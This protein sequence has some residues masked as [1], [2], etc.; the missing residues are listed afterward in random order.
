MALGDHAFVRRAPVAP[1]P[2]PRG[3]VGPLA[4]LRNNL[5]SS[6]A[7][8]ATTILIALFLA[9]TVPPLIRWLFI[10]AAWTGD[11]R[12]VCLDGG[13]CWA[14]IGAKINLILYGQYPPD[15][16]W[17]IVLVAALFVAGLVPLAI[18]R[19]PG[20]RWNVVYLLVVFPVIAF[21]LLTGIGIGLDKVPTDRWGG[22]FVTLVAA[23][24]GIVI[25]LPLGILLALGRRSKLPVVRWLS[26][27][28]IEFWRGVPLVAVLFMASVM[29]PIFLPPGVTFDKLLRAMLCIAIF[30]SAYMAEVVRGGLQAVPKGQYEGSMA[31]GLSWF[32]QMRLVVM[33]QALTVVIPGIV[34]TF[35]ALFK[36]TSLIMVIGLFDLLGMLKSATN[37]S[38]W[39]SPSVPATAYVFAGIIYW[40]FCFGLS[41][42]SV[43]IERRLSRGK[44]HR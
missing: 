17:R 3:V 11:D 40:V 35:I 41:R 10:D 44:L 9:W 36:D 4:W 24:M 2:P 34:N 22:L 5:F 39:A 28:F 32:Q 15:E 33:P 30:Y 37:D 12:S 8:T 29:L 6:P 16:R 18:P 31:L 21:M 27:A 19:V 7:N 14:F 42:Y 20:K 26:T 38:D 13:A 25:S 23:V 1:R 43:F